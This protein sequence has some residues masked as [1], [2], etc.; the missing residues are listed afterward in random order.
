MSGLKNRGEKVSLISFKRGEILVSPLVSTSAKCTAYYSVNS[1]Y[2]Y[3]RRSLLGGICSGISH[4]F[5]YN[6]TA[7]RV[8]MSIAI[9]LT[10]T[11]AGLVIYA[12]FWWYLPK[13]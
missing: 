12:A 6:L 2:R 3:S 1:L 11:V 5:G 10:G 13:Y 9:I 8:L 4:K 7:V